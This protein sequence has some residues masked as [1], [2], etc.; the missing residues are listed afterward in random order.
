MRKIAVGLVLAMSAGVAAAGD[1][2]EPRYYDSNDYAAQV[3]YRVDFGGER[4][5]AQSLGLRLDSERGAAAGMPSLFQ[6]RFGSQGLD[7]L[8][9]SGLDLRGMML[10]SQQSGGGMS[11]FFANMTTAQWIGLGVIGTAFLV[12][13]ADVS[14]GE[15]EPGGTGSGG[16]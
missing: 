13:A 16:N 5:Q 9:V 7:R 3:Y 2:S 6:A 15:S 14:E 11:G 1:L 8:A 10:A 12:V 4:G